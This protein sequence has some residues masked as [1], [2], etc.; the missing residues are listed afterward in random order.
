MSHVPFPFHRGLCEPGGQLLG[1]MAASSGAGASGSEDAGARS[2]PEGSSGS[3][4]A[5]GFDGGEVELL[6]QWG[7]TALLK[8]CSW[9]V[10]RS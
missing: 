9:N 4:S 10:S 1:K 6:Q 7:I 3:R 8:C 5:P 2:R